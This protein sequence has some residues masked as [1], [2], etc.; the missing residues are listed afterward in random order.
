[1]VVLVFLGVVFMVRVVVLVSSTKPVV[2]LA[3]SLCV[4][5]GPFKF[6]VL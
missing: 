5:L 3:G 1:M 2:L 6:S 4:E